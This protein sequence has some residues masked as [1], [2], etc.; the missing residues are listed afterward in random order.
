MIFGLV[1]KSEGANLAPNSLSCQRPPL[2]AQANRRAIIC[3]RR[4]CAIISGRVSLRCSAAYPAAIAGLGR[5]VGLPFDPRPGSS[6]GQL[7]PRA[8][9]IFLS[10]V[11]KCKHVLSL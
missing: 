10:G 2:R 6:D 11:P 3:R 9:L 4:S 1:L 8:I 7:Q 5:I